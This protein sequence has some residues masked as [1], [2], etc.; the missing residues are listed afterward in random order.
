VTAKW[1]RNALISVLVLLGTGTTLFVQH[2]SVV[3]LERENQSLRQQIEG[4]P[5]LAAENERLSD[6][7][8]EATSQPSLPS[9]QFRELLRLRGE[10]GLLRQEIQE[11][12]KLR[13]ENARLRAEAASPKAAPGAAYAGAAPEREVP[14]ESWAFAGYATPEAA[15]QSAIWACSR[16][17]LKTFLASLTEEGRDQ[18]VREKEGQSESACA[19]EGIRIMGKFKA[20]RVDGREDRTNGTLVLTASMIRHDGTAETERLTVKRVG[21]EWKLCL[22]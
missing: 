13:K 2:R 15:S 11:A 17:D 12:D 22:H 14:K 8:A 9:G 3:N 16:G 19:V 4:M 20:F 21:T 1:A 10:V 5:Q 6:L 7:V 18:F